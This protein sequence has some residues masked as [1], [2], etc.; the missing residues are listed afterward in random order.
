MNKLDLLFEK[1]KNLDAKI[2]NIMKVGIRASFI[3]CIISAFILFTYEFFYSLPSLFYIGISL[4]QSSLMF[5]STFLI[6][7]IGFDTIKKQMI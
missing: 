7:G 6:C 5:L 2:K 1:I 3:L 4:L